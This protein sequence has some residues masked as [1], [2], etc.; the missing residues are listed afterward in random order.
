[1][2][3]QS[4][5]G[6][7]VSSS[8]VDAVKRLGEARELAE[9]AIQLKLSL[10]SDLDP[11]Y[12]DTLIGVLERVDAREAEALVRRLAARDTAWVL[13]FVEILIDNKRRP[14]LI[15]MALDQIVVETEEDKATLDRLRKSLPA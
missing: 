5:Q 8:D 4:N 1:M 10:E 6:N 12:Q 3:Q 7:G 9:Q 11:N 15:N 13:R 2:D 14:D